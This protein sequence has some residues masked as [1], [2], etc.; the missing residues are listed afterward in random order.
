MSTLLIGIL[1][2]YA[3]LVIGMFVASL[4]AIAKSGELS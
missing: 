2:F 1:C 4:C 3:G